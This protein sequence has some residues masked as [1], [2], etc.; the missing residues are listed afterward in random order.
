MLGPDK[1]ARS[2]WKE[3]SL[4]AT[5]KKAGTAFLFLVAILAKEITSKSEERKANLWVNLSSRRLN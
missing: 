2:Y 1:T 4:T 3:G 5:S